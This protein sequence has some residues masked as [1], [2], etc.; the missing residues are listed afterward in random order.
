MSKGFKTA[1]GKDASKSVSKH[2]IFSSGSVKT[3]GKKISITT[4][5]LV[6]TPRGGN[7]VI[8]PPSRGDRYK[9]RQAINKY[10]EK[11]AL[12][13]SSIQPVVSSTVKA[14]Y[15]NPDNKPLLSRVAEKIKSRLKV[16]PE[17][18]DK[19]AKWINSIFK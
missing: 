11:Q 18:Q 17:Q 1:Y 14:A 6:A 3:T 5:Q 19:N 16:N 4:D 10:R 13:Q 12:D 7:K 9:Q 2:G 15:K 8:P